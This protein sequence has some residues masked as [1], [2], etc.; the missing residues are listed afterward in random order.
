[1]FDSA[2]QSRETRRDGGKAGGENGGQ[3]RWNRLP[4]AALRSRSMNEMSEGSSL[5]E[6]PRPDRDRTGRENEMIVRTRAAHPPAV[7]TSLGGCPAC[8]RNARLKAERRSYP[9]A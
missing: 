7:A 8:L 4:R 2:F 3:P 5:P 6:E 1:M 9:T